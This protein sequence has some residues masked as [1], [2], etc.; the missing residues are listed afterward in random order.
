MK[1]AKRFPVLFLRKLKLLTDERQNSV[2]NNA[3][4]FRFSLLVALLITNEC[5]KTFTQ[6]NETSALV[7]IL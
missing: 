1:T 5:M 7:Y 3:F 6:T 4:G 2:E